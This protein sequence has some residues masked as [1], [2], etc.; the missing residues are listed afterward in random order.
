M[1][2]CESQKEADVYYRGGVKQ[3]VREIELNGKLSDMTV[4]VAGGRPWLNN[5]VQVSLWNELSQP[6]AV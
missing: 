5:Q 1:Q 3:S 2:L 6:E 4:E